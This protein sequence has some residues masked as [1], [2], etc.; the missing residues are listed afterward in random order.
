VDIDPL[1]GKHVSAVSGLVPMIAAATGE[2]PDRIDQLLVDSMCWPA[3]RGHDTWP[4]SSRRPVGVWGSAAQAGPVFS[5]S[6]ERRTLMDCKK[7]S[8]GGRSLAA[9]LKSHLT[10][11]G[12]GAGLIRAMQLRERHQFGN[13]QDQSPDDHRSSGSH[14]PFLKCLSRNSE[15]AHDGG[16][17]RAS[18]VPAL[19]P[20][21]S[22]D[23]VGFDGALAAYLSDRPGKGPFLW[24]LDSVSF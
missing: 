7:Q 23:A 3:S 1:Y 6:V 8:S 10:S 14:P 2:T 12:L 17:G 24:F 20:H 13:A 4:R 9:G 19:R 15:A 11:R 16:R 21:R 22:A 5:T 18:P